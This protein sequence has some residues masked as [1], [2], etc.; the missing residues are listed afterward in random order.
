M[1]RAWPL[2]LTRRPDGP[3]VRPE[4]A[5]L[6]LLP[7]PRRIACDEGQVDD[8]LDVRQHVWSPRRAARLPSH[9]QCDPGGRRR[10]RSCRRRKRRGR[11]SSPGAAAHTTTV[12]ALG[13]PSCGHSGRCLD[14]LRPSTRRPGPGPHRRG[15]ESGRR[16]HASVPSR[17]Q[18]IGFRDRHYRYAARPRCPRGS[19]RVRVVRRSRPASSEELRRPAQKPACKPVRDR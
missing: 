1:S 4:L 19:R 18:R 3:G 16:G 2:A 12:R 9:R 6:P 7:H 14:A 17:R 15:A 11:P 13:R 8:A 10:T 5:F